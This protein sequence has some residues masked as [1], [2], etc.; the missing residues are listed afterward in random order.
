M[1]TSADSRTREMGADQASDWVN[2]Y[3]SCETRTLAT[4]LSVS[5]ANEER[6]SA[7]ESQLHAILEL[8]STGF[9]E[10]EHIAHLKE[11][12]QDQLPAEL[13]EYVDDLLGG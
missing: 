7:L 11:I 1:I 3:T 12:S 9:V 8:T 13:S 5:A 6:T 2:S 10:L 4:V